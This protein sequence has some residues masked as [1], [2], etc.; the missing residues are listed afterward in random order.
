[1]PGAPIRR[2]FQG[3]AVAGIARLLLG[4]A[5]FFIGAVAAHAD[6]PFDVIVTAKSAQVMDAGTPIGEIAVGT[7]LTVSQTNG[8]WYLVAVP[9][10]NPPRQGWISKADVRVT[11]FGLGPV[12]PTPEQRKSRLDERDRLIKEATDLRSAGQLDAAIRA[13]QQALAIDDALQGH[14]SAESLIALSIL[15]EAHGSAHDFAGARKFR[16]R[17]LESRTRTLGKNHWQAIDARIALERLSILEKLN[18]EQLRQLADADRLAASADAFCTA[19]RFASAVEPARKAAD[20][21]AAIF[22]QKHPDY[23]TSLNNLAYAL[24]GKGDYVDAEP[25]FERASAIRKDA[26]GEKHPDYAHTLELLG[27]RHEK[28]GDYAGADTL[29]RQVLAIHQETLGEKDPEY[30]VDLCNLSTLY[31]D[32]GDYVQAAMY[33]ARAV[34]ILKESVGGQGPVYATELDRLAGFYAKLADYAKAEPLYREAIAIRK[35]IYGEKHP[36]YA[37]SLNNLAVMYDHRGEYTKAEPLYLQALAIRKEVLGDTDRSYSPTLSNLAVLYEEMGEYTKA[38]PL[39]IEA[40]SIAKATFGEKHLTYARRLND[41]ARLYALQGDF[42]K[43]EPIAEK[44][45]Q[46]ARDQLKLAAAIQSE[47]QQNVMRAQVWPILDMYLWATA[48]SKSSVEQA[49]SAVLS[50]KGEVGEIQRQSRRIHHLLVQSGSAE[51]IRLE[52]ELN[53]TVGRLAAMQWQTNLSAADREKAETALREKMER[54]Q[55]ALAAASV[56]FREQQGKQHRTPVDVRNA[57]PDSTVLVDFLGYQAIGP[58]R[59]Q[60]KPGELVDN[61]AAFVVRRDRP[62]KRINLGPEAPIRSAIKQWRQTFGMPNAG[63]GGA[64]EEL[65]RL[66]WAPLEAHVAGAAIVLISPNSAIAPLSWP[67]LPGKRPGSYLIDD[68]AIAVVPI[69]RLLPELMMGA[70][71]EPAPS[72]LLV[73]DVDF[74]A[75][76]GSISTSKPN[77]IAARDGSQFRWLSLPGTR[78]EVGAIRALFAR[79]FIGAPVTELTG[80]RATKSAVASVASRCEYLHFS[81]HGFFAPSDAQS[82][83]TESGAGARAKVDR[84]ASSQKDL[85]PIHIATADRNLLSGLVLAGANRGYA[86]GTDDGILTALEVANL[87][88]THVRLATL[89]A[90]ETGL[91]ESAG[92]E[93]LLGLQ[94]AFQ[95]AGAKSVVASLWKVPDKATQLLMARFYENLWQKK[96]SKIDA[97]R[98]AQLWL[99]HEG[100]NQ[101]GLARGIELPADTPASSDKAGSLSPYY[102]AAFVLSGDWR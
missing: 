3:A 101:P 94:R 22:G 92:G 70:A 99:L 23:A 79:K 51:A 66:V 75:D 90:C 52:S 15:A 39:C 40:A 9:A 6:Q 8:D 84:S 30:A 62:M 56:P 65:R 95:T 57:L 19:G 67:A 45:A 88:L 12:P 29:Y 24:Y 97:L 1:M 63:G 93:G 89:S 10:A 46:I 76:P 77:Q 53:D 17:V 71:A 38:E 81:T 96:M 85:V 42:V 72:L 86:D 54:L 16:E 14:D 48:S 2:S 21:R 44:A 37:L 100:K 43:A 59:E 41:L 34:N 91:G 26:L 64:G 4:A 80:D 28:T 68:I 7:R 78:E 82:A 61:L 25:L 50:W 49:Y 33:T 35:E 83:R 18:S 11:T 32:M 98:D 36:Y 31:G 27:L 60:G 58:R 13:A 69:P 102:W 5:S 74:G 20:A 55:A 73:G 87:D 47:R